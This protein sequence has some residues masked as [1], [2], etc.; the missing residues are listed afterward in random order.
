ME[1]SQAVG[2]FG[3]SDQAPQARRKP[4]PAI[5]GIRQRLAGYL[6]Q[7]PLSDREKAY[8]HQKT[9]DILARGGSH[10][11]VYR[12]YVDFIRNRP[13]GAGTLDTLA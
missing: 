11:Q 2:R 10:A 3:L 9:Q 8:M 5:H 6:E 7:H 1:I 12:A 13:G 4:E